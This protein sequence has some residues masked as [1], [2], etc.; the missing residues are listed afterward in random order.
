MDEEFKY[1]GML[2]LSF[3]R[4]VRSDEMNVLFD[5]SGGR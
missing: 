3:Q 1:G 2:R 4:I 5:R